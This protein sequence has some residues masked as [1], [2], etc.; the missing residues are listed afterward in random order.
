M[1]G[2]QDEGKGLWCRIAIGYLTLAM[3]LPAVA[4]GRALEKV[5]MWITLGALGQ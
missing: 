1:D 4:G 5:K 2:E 3:R